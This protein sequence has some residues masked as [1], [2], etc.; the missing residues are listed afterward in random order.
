L[1]LLGIIVLLR[2][3]PVNAIIVLSM[4][5]AATGAAY[6]IVTAPLFPRQWMG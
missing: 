6:A 5:L 3:R 2:V 1:F 4:A